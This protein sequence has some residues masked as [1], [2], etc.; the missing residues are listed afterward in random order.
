MQ[1]GERFSGAGRS[2]GKTEQ[3]TGRCAL[4]S[5]PDFLLGFGVTLVVLALGTLAL[6]CFFLR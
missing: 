6:H 5:W 4:V 2:P 3:R 1:S